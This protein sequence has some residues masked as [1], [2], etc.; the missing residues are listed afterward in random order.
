MSRAHW[1]VLARADLGGI[2]DFYQKHAPDFAEQ[3]GAAALKASRFLAE[4]PRAG[5]VLEGDIRKWR[6]T[7][8]DY[9]LLYRVAAGGI[10]VLRMHHVRQNWRRSGRD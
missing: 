6:I 5:A 4:R 2:D 8:F 1:T 3:L 9:V 10:E 7:G